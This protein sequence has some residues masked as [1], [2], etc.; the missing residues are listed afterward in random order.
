MYNNAISSIPTTLGNLRQLTHFK[1]ISSSVTALPDEIQSLS[2]LL[3]LCIFASL[4]SLPAWIGSLHKL[5]VLKLSG[6]KLIEIPS[7]LSNLS[8][9]KELD[10]SQN[11]LSTLPEELLKMDWLDRFAIHHN[12]LGFIP[13]L[14]FSQNEQK[15]SEIR[16]FSQRRLPP[17]Q[18]RTLD[19]SGLHLTH[20]PKILRHC[21]H[22]QMLDLSNNPLCHLPVWLSELTHIVSLNINNSQ[23]IR[24]PIGFDNHPHIEHF[25]SENN[26]LTSLSGLPKRCLNRFGDSEFAPSLSEHGKALL[27]DGDVNAVMVYYTP[28]PAELFRRFCTD[29]TSLSDEEL[30]RLIHELSLEECEIL[31][32]KFPADHPILH[33]LARQRHI[34]IEYHPELHLI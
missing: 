8:C 28:H 21:T 9:L 16:F 23:I 32:H 5:Q 7:S 3:S 12:P 1:F 22:L 25:S 26:V 18:I 17:S 31:K 15:S 13:P 2:N 6:N 20:L 4:T 24:F 10:L 14:M 29:E 33:K 34:P 27:D 30:D 11:L 19:L